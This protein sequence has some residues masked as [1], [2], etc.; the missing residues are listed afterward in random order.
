MY[1]FS[2]GKSVKWILIILAVYLA[3]GW[4]YNKF[5][6]KNNTIPHVSA[7]RRGGNCLADL[8]DKMFRTKVPDN[9][10]IITN[11]DN[12]G[13]G[14]NAQTEQPRATTTEENDDH[15]LPM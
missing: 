2:S 4:L 1:N 13:F 3:G 10:A 12:P 9:N 15:L 7:F 6:V 11:G 14:N 5:V 8:C